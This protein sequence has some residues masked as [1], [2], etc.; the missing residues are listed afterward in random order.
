M[1]FLAMSWRKTMSPIGCLAVCVD[2]TVFKMYLV[3]VRKQLCMGPAY[4]F[5]WERHFVYGPSHRFVCRPCLACGLADWRQNACRLFLTSTAKTIPWRNDHI[6]VGH[7]MKTHTLEADNEI[8]NCKANFYA[9][10]PHTHT[11]T[12]KHTNTHTHSQSYTPA[13]GP[14]CGKKTTQCRLR[15]SACGRSSG[16]CL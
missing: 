3:I 2:L 9:A 6:L 5:V 8:H 1:E 12:H 10:H 14:R 13:S 7:R 15:R 4:C 16:G 11:H